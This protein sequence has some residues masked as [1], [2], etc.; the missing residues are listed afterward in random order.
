MSHDIIPRPTYGID[1]ILSGAATAGTHPR[2]ATRP[3]VK[4]HGH[5]SGERGLATRIVLGT[6]ATAVVLGLTSALAL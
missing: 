1:S 4:T 3:P 6:L 5:A 2:P